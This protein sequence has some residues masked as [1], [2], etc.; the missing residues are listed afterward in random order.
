MR[1]PASVIVNRGIYFIPRDKRVHSLSQELCLSVHLFICKRGLVG[2]E[3]S[4]VIRER[5]YSRQSWRRQSR[6]RGQEPIWSLQCLLLQATESCI[7]CNQ[8]GKYVCVGI[9]EACMHRCTR[10]A[11]NY[12]TKIQRMWMDFEPNVNL[13]IKTQHY[14]FACYWSF[15]KVINAI[16]LSKIL[17]LNRL[18]SKRCLKNQWIT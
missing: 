5:D 6:Q 11:R 2:K 10:H 16:S 3:S 14:L 17:F 7:T 12:S 13:L 8:C 18:M 4:E 15:H 1:T 9:V